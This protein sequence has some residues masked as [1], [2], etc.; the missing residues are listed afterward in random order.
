M[1]LHSEH[2]E[3]VEIDENSMLVEE[4][5]QETI[6]DSK[7]N[8]V[9]LTDPKNNCLDLC[10]IFG[11][12]DR[13]NIFIEKAK[14]NG[15]LQCFS[16]KAGDINIIKEY[17]IEFFAD[18]KESIDYINKIHSLTESKAYHQ[19]K[20]IISHNNEYMSLPKTCKIINYEISNITG[21]LVLHKIVLMTQ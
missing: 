19:F 10:L 16:E 21:N 20:Y 17:K 5:V 13:N 7:G 14:F 4:G 18:I 15:F 8:D 1:I 11:K 3:E 9:F 2:D 6:L 12:I